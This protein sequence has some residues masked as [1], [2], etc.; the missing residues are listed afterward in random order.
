MIRPISEMT[1]HPYGTRLAT[2]SAVAL[3]LVLIGA[4]G[5]SEAV[6]AAEQFVGL[7]NSRDFSSAAAL[8]CSLPGEVLDA[9][10]LSQNVVGTHPGPFEIVEEFVIENGLIKVDV[11]QGDGSSQLLPFKLE[12]DGKW[13]YC[14]T[15]SLS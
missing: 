5:S 7:L 2:A 13:R 11:S 4:C 8:T 6:K 12:P 9:D 14:P 3:L 1:T 10:Y 15:T